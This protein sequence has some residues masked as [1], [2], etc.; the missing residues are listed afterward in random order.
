MDP[1]GTSGKLIRAIMD[2]SPADA[3]KYIARI[4]ALCV[5]EPSYSAIAAAR[6]QLANERH[7]DRDIAAR[8]SIIM[9]LSPQNVK[10]G[11]KELVYS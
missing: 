2:V 6:K 11:S 5:T 10:L 9:G 8:A 4:Q 1:D 3:R 7:T